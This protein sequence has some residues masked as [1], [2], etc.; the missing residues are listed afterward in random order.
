MGKH[1]IGTTQ[2]L[3]KIPMKRYDVKGNDIFVVLT[4]GKYYA[5]SNRC[6]HEEAYFSQEGEVE[7]TTVTCSRHGARFDLASGAVKAL[8][9]VHP[10]KTY[11]LE[12]EGNDMFIVFE[13]AL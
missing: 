7:G 1:W 13:D 8:P 12:I 9:A 2:E 5:V 11:Q 3:E 4:Q 10:L 6:T